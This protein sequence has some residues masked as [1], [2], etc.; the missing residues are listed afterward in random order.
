MLHDLLEA[1]QQGTTTSADGGDFRKHRPV[2]WFP[3]FFEGALLDYE[4][5][6]QLSILFGSIENHFIP[7]SLTWFEL[8]FENSPT[9]F[10]S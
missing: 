4:F 2:D 8:A 3:D 10:H 5:S 6:V 9:A 1:A 7:S